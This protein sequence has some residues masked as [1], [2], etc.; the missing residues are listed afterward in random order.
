MALVHVAPICGV[1]LNIERVELCVEMR[2]SRLGRWFCPGFYQPSASSR[3][4]LKGRQ[5]A[6][7]SNSL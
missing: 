7:L 1:G 6:S 4:L 3:W 5:I 2:G